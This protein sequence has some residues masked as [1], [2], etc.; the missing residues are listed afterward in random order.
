ML[1]GLCRHWVRIELNRLW[2]F[3]S[4]VLAHLAEMSVEGVCL[5][6]EFG[7]CPQVT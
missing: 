2:C 5:G 1:L 4:N 6:G 3:G 7:F